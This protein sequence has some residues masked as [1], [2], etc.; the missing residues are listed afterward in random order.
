MDSKEKESYAI[1]EQLGISYERIDHEPITSVKD[2]EVEL[3]GQQVKCLVLKN[4]KGRQYYFV[5]LHDEKTADL[6]LL[7]QALEE[8]R[9]SFASE[10]ALMTL[11]QCVPGTVTPFGL[12]YDTEFKV[13]VIVDESVDTSLTVGFHPYVNTT[14]LNIAYGDFERLVTHFQHT[15]QKIQF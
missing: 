14:T 12:Q 15:I 9:L 4:K 1:L 6:K 8:N 10:E 7:A 11:L 3:P 13:Q 2:L 5:I